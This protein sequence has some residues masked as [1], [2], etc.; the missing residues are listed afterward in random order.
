[1]KAL[2]LT[3]LF[4]LM[5]ARYDLN[6]GA[7]KLSHRSLLRLTAIYAA[8]F[9]VGNLASNP[10]HIFKLQAETSECQQTY[11]ITLTVSGNHALR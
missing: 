4:L 6:C 2:I 8:R 7:A 1:M 9:T 10:L 3:A 11:H 5:F